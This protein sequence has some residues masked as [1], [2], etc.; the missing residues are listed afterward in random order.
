MSAVAVGL[1][2]F[3]AIPANAYTVTFGGD[4]DRFFSTLDAQIDM[5]G[6]FHAEGDGAA[7]D[8]KANRGKGAITPFVLTNPLDHAISLYGGHRPSII[9][10][11]MVTSIT[12][13]PVPSIPTA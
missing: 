9:M 12:S 7:F 1:A 6:N 11:S 8:S 2:A 10:T 5:A 3:F 13:V 4:L